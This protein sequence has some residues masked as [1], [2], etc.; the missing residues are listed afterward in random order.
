MHLESVH[1]FNTFDSSTPL[2]RCH[3]ALDREAET[4]MAMNNTRA[5]PLKLSDL[6]ILIR[7][8]GEMATGCACRLHSSGFFRM[9]MTEI[10]R[11][12][13]VRRSVSLCEVMYERSWTVENVRAERID[14]VEAAEDFWNQRVI[15]AL[16]D[17]EASCKTILKPDVLIDAILAK[18]NLGTS[19]NDAPLVIALGPG[20]CAGR[21]AHYVVETDRGHDLAR[22]ITE[23]YASP[24]TGV[25]GPIAGYS[26]LRVLRSPAKGVFESELSIGTPV[27][28]GQVI[29]YVSGE[30]VT[31]RL[32]G[33][34]RGLI[35]PGSFVTP[36]LKIGDIDPRGDAS[37]CSRISEKARAI[38][39][40]VLEAIMRT[41][42]V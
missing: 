22:L 1:V 2:Q 34:L 29:G 12:L 16:V 10:D 14:H 30:P 25:P 27:E 19:I 26:V 31:A 6:R 35:R 32:D 33:L 39:G 7:G 8:G 28:E 23:G 24:N 41:Y 5:K 9:L 18:R 38:A 15:P 42:N 36:N 17:P 37:Y 40:A 21:D 3:H 11:P 4:V 20:F 13:A